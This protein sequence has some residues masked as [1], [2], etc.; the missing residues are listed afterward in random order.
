[1]APAPIGETIQCVACHNEAAA[2]MTS[3]VFPSGA[4]VTGMDASA[5]CA[6]CHQ[7]RASMVQ[8]NESIDAAG[9]VDD[10]DS[11][12]EELGFINI[13]YY[14]AAA[15]LYGSEVMGGY[16]YDGQAYTPRF[17]H[18]EGYN[19]CIGCHNSH[20]LELKIEECQA[21]HQDVT[22]VEDVANIRMASSAVDYDG[23]GDLEEGI[24]GEI[25]SLQ[26][27]LMTAMQAYATEV[28]GSPIAYSQTSYPYFFIDADE[29]GEATE[30]DTERFVAW[31]PRLLKAAYNYQVSLKDPG[32]YAHNGKYMIQLLHDSIM[33]LNQSIS[34]PVDL[35][36][37]VRDDPGHFAAEAEAFRHWDEEGLVPGSCAKCHSASGLPVFLENGANIAVHPSSGLNCSTCH[38]NLAEFTIY[39]VESVTFPSGATVG[40]DDSIESNLCLNCHQ[41]RES[42]VSI[43]RA[44]AS[45]GVGDNEVS[46]A[47]RFR[48]PHYFAAGATLFGSEVSGAYEYD[49]Q[50]YNGRFLHVPNFDTCTECHDAHALAV[51]VAACAGC[52]PGADEEGGLENIRISTEDYDGDGDVTEGIA[53]EIATMEERLYEAL[54]AYGEANGAPIEFNP[55]RYPYWFDDAGEGFAQWTPAL[56]RAAYNY[57]WVAKDPG[58]FAH[59][60]TYILQVLYDSISAIGDPTGLT[61]P[62][63]TTGAEQAQ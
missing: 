49:G 61:R 15:T 36:G 9:L 57:T 50:E 44:I 28:A 14:A 38:D 42:T 43:N 35:M 19:S 58:A 37:A 10:P 52:H 51:N 8:V 23:D 24:K 53:G 22:S 11:V 39:Q 12:S 31:T 2:Q 25:E 16:Q 20:T 6:Q 33:D 59:N 21:C 62:A 27:S 63:V 55:A 13:H 48:N 41:G 30:A 47:L 54:Q 1:N 17:D 7:G 46:E 29:D 5:R 34:T 18:V 60:S 26:A 45:A 56:L 40:F 32:A 3:V 4:E